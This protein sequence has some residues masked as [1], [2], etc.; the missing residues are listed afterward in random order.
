MD[1]CRQQGRNQW[2]PFSKYFGKAAPTRAIPSSEDVDDI[3]VQTLQNGR[4]TRLPPE[5]L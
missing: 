4:P 3:L 1:Q 2:Q 5:D